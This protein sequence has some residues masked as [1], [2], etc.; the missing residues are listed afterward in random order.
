MS[1]AK[2]YSTIE[3]MIRQSMDLPMKDKLSTYNITIPFTEEDL[4]DLLYGN[5]T[6]DWVFPT[7]EDSS[8]QINV[9][10]KQQ[11]EDFFDDEWA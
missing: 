6:F 10:L 9:K 3:G 1:S 5:R 8:I 2:G 7:D 11:E 4:N